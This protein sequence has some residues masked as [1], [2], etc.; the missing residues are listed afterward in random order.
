MKPRAV[1]LYIQN[2]FGNV[3][4][5][6]RKDDHNSFG[7]VGGKVDETDL[8]TRDALDR[9]VLEETGVDISTWAAIDT[10]TALDDGCLVQAFI[11]PSEASQLFPQIKTEIFEGSTSAFVDFKN[12]R[13]ILNQEHSIF[14]DY[15]NLLFNHIKEKGLNLCQ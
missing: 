3:L 4:T 9:E 7:L 15:N 6:T 14:A 5:I 10:F 8:T 11:L 2:Q 1:V 13:F 12:H